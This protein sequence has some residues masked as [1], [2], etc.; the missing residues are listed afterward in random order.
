MAA[1][2]GH[3]HDKSHEEMGSMDHAA[4]GDMEAHNCHGGNKNTLKIT[5]DVKTASCPHCYISAPAIL[6]DT[7]VLSLIAFDLPNNE[8]INNILLSSKGS[9]LKLNLPP[10]RY[11]NPIYIINSSYI[12]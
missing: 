4:G 6:K 12:I 11:K 7:K 9:L 1:T 2:S 10:P 5:D 3:A 8:G